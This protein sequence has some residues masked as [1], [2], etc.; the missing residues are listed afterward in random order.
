V[1]KNNPA[2]ANNYQAEL[3]KGLREMNNEAFGNEQNL[4]VSDSPKLA[5]LASNERT[6]TD[7]QPSLDPDSIRRFCQ[8]WGEI[9]RAILARRSCV[10]A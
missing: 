9:G 1:P 3:I 2:N 8:T 6:C 4:K 5:I 10:T 7:A